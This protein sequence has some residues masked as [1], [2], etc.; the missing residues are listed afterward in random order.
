[1]VKWYVDASFAVHPNM[2]GHTGGISTLGQGAQIVVST[3]QKMKKG[4]SMECKLVGLDDL[5]PAELWVR[6][7]LS[8]RGMK[9]MIILFIR[10]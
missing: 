3:K 1:M 4:S 10:K 8:A 7:F 5:M 9:S 2:Q 6:C